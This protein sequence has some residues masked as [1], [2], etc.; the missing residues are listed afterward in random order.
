M[1]ESFYESFYE[2]AVMLGE[3][4]AHLYA[5]QFSVPTKCLGTDIDGSRIIVKLEIGEETRLVVFPMDIITDQ[6]RFDRIQKAIWIQH[7]EGE[8]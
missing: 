6:S 4:T 7:G 5:Q 3:E 1:Y 2:S 8:N